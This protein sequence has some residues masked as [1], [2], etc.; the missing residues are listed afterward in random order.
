MQLYSQ[1][2]I[3]CVA[4]LC[5]AAIHTHTHEKPPSVLN[6]VMLRWCF[7]ACTDTEIPT[8]QF[9]VIR[10]NKCLVNQTLCATCVLSQELKS[11]NNCLNLVKRN[12]AKLI[13]GLSFS[14]DK[15]G[16]FSFSYMGIDCFVIWTKQ[17]IWK[18]HFGFW[19]NVIF[20]YFMT[21]LWSFWR[22]QCV[23]LSD[24]SELFS[25]LFYFDN[26]FLQKWR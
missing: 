13:A 26:P 2:R 8:G 22:L 11:L 4:E 23:E 5:N 3:K 17:A 14:N 6:S 19:E 21:T 16:I 25:G 7:N 1:C 15:I 20:H 24:Y 10:I 18:H 9:S 12:N